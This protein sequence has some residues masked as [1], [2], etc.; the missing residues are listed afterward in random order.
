V[1]VWSSPWHV[2]APG[3]GSLT[4][5]AALFLR[6]HPAGQRLLARW[7]KKHEKG[8]AL[9]ILAHTL[10]RAVYDMLKRKTAFDMDTFLHG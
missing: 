10:A 5:A 4:G 8:K 6:N 9:P 3:I 2:S 7:E 1:T